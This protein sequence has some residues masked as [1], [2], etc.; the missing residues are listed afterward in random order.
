MRMKDRFP[1]V[2]YFS[3]LLKTIDL[4]SMYIIT[5]YLIK[6]VAFLLQFILSFKFFI[7]EVL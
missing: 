1:I 7:N 5:F 4:L 2:Y 6:A 3:K